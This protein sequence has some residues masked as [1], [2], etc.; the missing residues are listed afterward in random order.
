MVESTPS[1]A[2][3]T[4]P[5]PRAP[6]APVA[7]IIVTLLLGG[8]GF[9]TSFFGFFLPMGSDNCAEGDP[10]L[11]CTA[12]GQSL[13]AVGP[14][15]AAGLGMLLAVVGCIRWPRGDW[16]LWMIA[17]FTATIIGFV[18]FAGIATAAN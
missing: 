5:P 8:L 15:V 14:L 13:V 17:G 11:I 10:H 7:P 3:V 16:G 1:G 4:P 12:D 18:V 6:G 9:A 2:Q